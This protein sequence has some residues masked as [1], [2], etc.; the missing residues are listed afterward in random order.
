M[1][2]HHEDIGQRLH[3]IDRTIFHALRA[4]HADMNVPMELRECVRQLGRRSSQ[5]QRALLSR[6]THG[7]RESVNDLARISH[8]A[9][10]A[11][12]PAAGM[13]YEVKSAVILAHI[14]VSALRHQLD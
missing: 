11:I 1:N 7:L 8:R 6:D 2:A 12:D 4:C 10:S 5:A 13:T 14:E 3:F 9:Q